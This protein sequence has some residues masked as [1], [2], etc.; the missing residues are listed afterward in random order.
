MASSQGSGGADSHAGLTARVKNLM[1]Q[2]KQELADLVA[3]P[4]VSETGYPEKTWPALL[5]TRD[6]VAKLFRDAGC[7]QV[8]SLELPDTAP[9]I[10]G[11]IPAPPGAPTVL[12]Y[13]HYDVVPAGDEAEWNTR[14]PSSPPSATAPCTG[15][16]RPTPSRTSWP[17]SAPCAPG[18][19]G[20]PW[21]SNS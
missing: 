13:S 17:W 1:P 3:I 12:L 21:A 19:G 2:L 10:L 8:E 14:R 7:E 4:S 16:A 5:Q 6:A 9:I 18:T 11:G 15:A 20:R